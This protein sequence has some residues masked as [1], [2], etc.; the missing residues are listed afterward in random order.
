MVKEKLYL[1][2]TL[3]TISIGCIGCSNNVKLDDKVVA[4]YEQILNNELSNPRYDEKVLHYGF[5]Y[6]DSDD[7]EEL[8]IIRGTAHIDTVTVYSYDSVNEK[9]VYIGDFG[10]FGY[11]QYVPQENRIISNYGNQGYYYTT[12]TKINGDCRPELVECY[13][14]NG[15]NKVESYYGF[16]MN[17]FTGAIDWS[18]YDI[19]QWEHPNEEYFISEMLADKIDKRVKNGAINVDVD[20]FCTMEYFLEK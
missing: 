10:G 18:D 15:G 7:I 20:S 11:C 12:V 17:D 5:G 14:R 9:A 19:N 6:I 13:L 4:A 8:F 3:S 2:A 16:D 1:A